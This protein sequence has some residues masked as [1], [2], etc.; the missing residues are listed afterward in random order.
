MKANKIRGD[1]KQDMNCCHGCIGE[2]GNDCCVDTYIILHQDECNLFK[3]YTEFKKVTSG[4]IFNTTKGC[5]YYSSGNCGIHENKPLYCKYYP[6][7]ITGKPFVHKE[8]SIN[9]DYTLTDKIRKKIISLQSRYPIYKKDWFWEE[10]ENEF[11]LQEG[12]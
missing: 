4:G 8:C 9:Q 11:T 3:H 2:N 10:V 7:F 5:P 12:N 6:I 1:K